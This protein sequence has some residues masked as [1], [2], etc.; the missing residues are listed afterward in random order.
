MG[1]VERERK[2]QKER[3]KVGKGK[4]ETMGEIHSER[5]EGGRE[6]K[7]SEERRC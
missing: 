5:R 3:G 1:G 7:G 6:G 2:G 4:E